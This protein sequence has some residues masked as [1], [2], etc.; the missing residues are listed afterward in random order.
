LLLIRLILQLLEHTNHQFS[1]KI[2]A[3]IPLRECQFEFELKL[4]QPGE[5]IVEST[6][7][8]AAIN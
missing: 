6:V 8:C 3:K 1:A 4:Q 5:T 2:P 7:P